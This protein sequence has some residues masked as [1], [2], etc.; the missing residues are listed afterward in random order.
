LVQN[1]RVR[2]FDGLKIIVPIAIGMTDMKKENN[3]DSNEVSS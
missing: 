3:E 1:V 2:G